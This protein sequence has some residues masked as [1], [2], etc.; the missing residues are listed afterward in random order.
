MNTNTSVTDISESPTI[1]P[2]WLMPVLDVVLV[3]IAFTLAYVIRY[4]LQI[5]RPVFD[6]SRAE[7]VPYL[8]F[9]AFY[10]FILYLTCQG[11]GLYKNFRG[12]TLIEEITLIANG[13]TTGTVILLAL[14]Y[15]FQ[16]LVTSRLMLIYVV[17][18]TVILLSATRLIRRLW[19][20]Y[21]RS[22]GIG[23]QRVLI[24]GMSETGQ[25]VLRVMVS[26]RE[27]GYRVVGYLDD[28]PQRG[29]VDLG[30]V[31]GLGQL[32]NLR[33]SIRKQQV[34]TVVITLRWKHYDRIQ[35]LARICRKAG[36]SVRVV[37]DIFQLNMRQVQVENLDGI[38][39]LGI[40]GVEPLRGTGR[41]FKRVMDMA[42]VLMA[43]PVW[44]TLFAIIAV[45][46]R[47]EGEGDV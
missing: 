16:P 15:L 26:R 29:E 17:A 45:A 7:F 21:L 33:E 6:P 28:N 5:I 35:E 37:P 46:M 8:P 18:L 27:L 41:L 3:F 25:A 14:Y 44:G 39:L 43:L 10:A 1:E 31:S 32:E 12:R 22:K 13:A 30:R 24:V 4:E 40:Q 9:T 34:D 47:L 36:V 2:R 20:A 11:N 42:L 38:P 23:T 19:L